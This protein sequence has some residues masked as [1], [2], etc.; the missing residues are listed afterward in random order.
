LFR[1]WNYSPARGVT[2][3]MRTFR[4]VLLFV[5]AL[6]LAQSPEAGRLI[7]E[8]NGKYGKLIVDNPRPL[9]S[10]AV[11]LAEKFGIPVSVEDP[12]YLYNDDVKDVTAA[13]SRVPNPARRVLVPKGG[14]LE[15]E[16]TLGPD[17]A[18]NEI[19]ALLHNLIN[20]ANAKF[21]FAYRLEDDGGVFTLIPTHTRNNLG[22]VIEITPLLDRRVSIPPST[23][24]IAETANLMT[25][26]LSAQT[27]LRV[28]CCQ[29]FVAGIPWGMKSVS[30][31]AH[32]EPARSILKRLIAS[33]LE[34]RTNGYHW[35]QRCDPLPSAWCFINLSYL[36]GKADSIRPEEALPQP[37]DQRLGRSKWFD[38]TP[39]KVTPGK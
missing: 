27:G 16:F 12:P 29:S 26:E 11:T 22:R 9:D 17:G 6:A 25:A 3:E 13:V 5:S 4:W 38:S 8:D 19:R 30:F 1:Y 7:L 33:D 24:S 39:S 23:R 34:G 32:N 37:P 18:P 20:H 2:S 14:T 21:P 10:A 28:S 36:P 15:I 35:L 31:E